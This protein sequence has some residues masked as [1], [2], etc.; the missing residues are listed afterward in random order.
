[1]EQIP[2]DIIKSIISYLDLPDINK[3]SQMN[4]KFRA[5][6]N[7]NYIWQERYLHDFGIKKTEI[8][9]LIVYKKRYQLKKSTVP[10]DVFLYAVYFLNNTQAKWE[11]F[12]NYLVQDENDIWDTL[13]YIYSSN[14]N[15]KILS[16][17][18]YIKALI[19]NEIK[20]NLKIIDKIKNEQDKQFWTNVRNEN[21][22]LFDKIQKKEHMTTDILK[23]ILKRFGLIQIELTPLYKTY[24][25]PIYL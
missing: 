15:S 9:A 6:C 11:L 20:N 18:E 21:E 23:F 24:T 7:D 3:V 1:M 22:A 10:L 25:N 16:I 2:L 4:Q 5:I 12:A 14:T 13:L 17:I 8:N 19:N